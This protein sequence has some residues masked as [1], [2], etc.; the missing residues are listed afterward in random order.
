M[1]KT[2]TNY[3][4]PLVAV[5]DGIASVRVKVKGIHRESPWCAPGTLLIQC[6]L[7]KTKKHRCRVHLSAVQWRQEAGRRAMGAHDVPPPQN[8]TLA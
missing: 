7:H 4:L 5:T 1:K 3:F 2:G 8:F 6:R